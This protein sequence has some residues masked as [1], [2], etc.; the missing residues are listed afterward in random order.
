MKSA[1]IINF[2]IADNAPVLLSEPRTSQGVFESQNTT[3]TDAV[4]PLIVNLQIPV[5][6]P[7]GFSVRD[8][9]TA[10]TNVGEQGGVFGSFTN[11]MLEP[12]QFLLPP[13][14]EVL[15]LPAIP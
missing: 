11:M 8:H 6:Q 12:L 2:G 3:R 13:G 1:N 14:V 5:G 15:S 7:F 4:A 10:S 9:A